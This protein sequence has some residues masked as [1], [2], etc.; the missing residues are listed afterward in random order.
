[1]NASSGGAV[2]M[3]VLELADD[4]TVVDRAADRGLQA[5][6]R[7][8][9]VRLEGL[10]HLH[11]LEHDDDVALGDG[12]TLLD[13]DLDDRALHG[14]GDR[15]AGGSSAGL[16]RGPLRLLDRKSTRLNSSH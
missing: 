16:L 10:L 6:H 3:S 11:R 2:L 15:V 8:G 4:G 9:L 14:G 1:M 5:A 13:G 7:S 12:R